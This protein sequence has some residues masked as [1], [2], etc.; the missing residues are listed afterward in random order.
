MPAIRRI[1]F[2][3]STVEAAPLEDTVRLREYLSVLWKRK[4]SVVAF[5]LVGLLG[6]YFF[7]QKETRQFTSTISV[8][9]TNPLAQIS[10]GGAPNMVSERSLV[11]S[12]PV[13]QCVT[14][15]LKNPSLNH[16][17]A[18]LDQLCSAK[19]LSTVVITPG[20]KQNLTVIV[21][22]C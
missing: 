22:T 18:N 9:V 16:L 15:I 7:T 21:P 14:L 5:I 8:V 17:G 13:A 11:F 12:Q 2:L 1:S 20:L 4:W 3:M 10:Q 19:S 6:A